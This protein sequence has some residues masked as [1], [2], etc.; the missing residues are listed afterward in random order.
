MLVSV[1]TIILN[2]I[3]SYFIYNDDNVFCN[4][5]IYIQE[6]TPFVT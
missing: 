6:E 2:R 5:S 4:Y 1:N 3:N